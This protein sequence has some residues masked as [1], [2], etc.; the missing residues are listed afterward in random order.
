MQRARCCWHELSACD[1][2]VGALC[3]VVVHAGAVARAMYPTLCSHVGSDA[4]AGMC[5]RLQATAP[6]AAAGTGHVE[7]SAYLIAMRGPAAGL[8]LGLVPVLQDLSCPAPQA[9]QS[10]LTEL[11]CRQQHLHDRD[12]MHACISRHDGRAGCMRMSLMS[13]QT[14]CIV[15]YACVCRSP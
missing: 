2:H 1:A 4:A 7:P 9:P 8:W 11:E 5:Q 3:V 10:C 15:P 14:Y 12:V 13:E 6:A